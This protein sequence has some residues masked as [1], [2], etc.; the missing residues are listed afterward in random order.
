MQVLPFLAGRKVAIEQKFDEVAMYRRHPK[1]QTNRWIYIDERSEVIEWASKHAWSFH[2]HIRGRDNWWFVIDIDGRGDSFDI[3]LIRDV[4]VV[5]AGIF[6]LRGMQYLVKYSGNRGF[7][8]M[9]EW[10]MGG[11]SLRGK[12]RWD[13]AK[14][15][16]SIFRNELEK[17]LSEESV[18]ASKLREIVGSG[19]PFTLTNSQETECKD[20]V[21]IDV[22]I[23]HVNANIRSPFSVHPKT[24]LVSIPLRGAKGLRSFIKEEAELDVVVNGDWKWVKMPVNSWIG[25]DI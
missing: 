21:L 25:S 7:H 12:N 23:L 1:G 14:S 20:A 5:M 22:N 10:A 24:G 16:A 11:V 9:W 6:D 15:I 4:A 18:L 2:P 13:E 8:F 19:C 17:R 3:D